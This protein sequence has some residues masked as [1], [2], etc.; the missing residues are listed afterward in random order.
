MTENE[1]KYDLKIMKNQLHNL[2][3][4][5]S[6][7]RRAIEMQLRVY[8]VVGVKDITT[9]QLYDAYKRGLNMQ[10]LVQ[11]ANGKY[12]AEEIYK[13]IRKAGGFWYECNY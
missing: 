13:K 9:A 2:Q 1:L 3:T 11:L 12:T 6:M 10:Q 8:V 4:L 7:L 5:T